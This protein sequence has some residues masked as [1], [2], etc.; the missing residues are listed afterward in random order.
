MFPVMST[1]GYE[2]LFAVVVS[3]SAAVMS[4]CGYEFL[5]FAIVVST[6][7][8]VMSTCGYEFL[9]AVLAARTVAYKPPS[10]FPSARS[11]LSYTVVVEAAYVVYGSS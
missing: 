2:F 9:F 6:S 10:P 7:A 4:T 5:S 1:C 8:A 3:T 11:L